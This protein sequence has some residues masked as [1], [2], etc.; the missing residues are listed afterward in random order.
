MSGM[1]TASTAAARG[2]KPQQATHGSK[3]SQLPSPVKGLLAGASPDWRLPERV[4][5]NVAAALPAAVHGLERALATD[6]S[7]E[8][9][10]VIC[11]LLT[12][13]P[14]PHR[15]PEHRAL[16]ARHWLEDLAEYPVAVVAEAAQDWRYTEKWAPKICELR[17]LCD[18]LVTRKRREL[19]R[20]R[21]LLACVARHGGRVPVLGTRVGAQ[22]VDYHDRPT[23]RDVEAWLRGEH[24]LGGDRVWSWPAA[25]PAPVP[26]PAP[27]PV[28]AHP[29]PPAPP[30]SR[31]RV[32]R[33][34]LA[35]G[36]TP[37]EI[38]AGNLLD[39]DE[40]GA[41]RHVEERQQAWLAAADP[42][43]S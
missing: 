36:L 29:P 3:P 4:P 18:G 32:L 14:E 11:D 13:Y 25:Q 20:A 43:L 22:V 38:D 16:V 9:A 15:T 7:E 5:A 24:E 1:P 35:A 41:R 12:L 21:F 26:A 17:A 8:R 23:D 31:Q 37:A 2:A 34:L 42:A 40:A 27:K 6:N 28:P 33:V 19:L 10:A 39:L 30:P